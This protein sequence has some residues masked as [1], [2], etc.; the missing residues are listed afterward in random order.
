MLAYAPEDLEWQAVVAMWELLRALYTDTPTTTDL[1]AAAVARKYREHCCKASCQWNYLL[2]LEED[3][4]EALVN[5]AGLGVGLG[6]VSAD[7][8]ESLNAI[9]KKAY[10]DLT[11]RGG[12][13]GGCRGQ[14]IWKGRGR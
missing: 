3:V 14:A 13:G 2:F 7:F 10:N 8:V 12:G 5:A 6:A 11:A 1:K 4:T 9:L